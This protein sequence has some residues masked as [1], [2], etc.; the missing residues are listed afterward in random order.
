MLTLFGGEPLLNLPVHIT[1]PSACGTCAGAGSS[2]ASAS[3][4]TASCLPPRS[5]DRLVACGLYGIKITLDG[6][7]E[8]HN[9]M[10]PLRGRQGTFDK[11][12]ENVRR[13]AAQGSDYHRRQLRRVE[14]RQLPALLDFLREQEFADKIVKINFKPIIKAAE[15]KPKGVIPLTL[16][17][18]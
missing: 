3:S 12:I 4:P 14:R 13:V 16:V 8:T 2:R 5:V 7:R 6:D 15:T 18:R 11:I 9:R 1:W 17:Q 10:R